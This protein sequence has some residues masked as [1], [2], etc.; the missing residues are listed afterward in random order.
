MMV[1]TL[2]L[3]SGSYFHKCFYDDEKILQDKDSVS[4]ILTS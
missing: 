2:D 1:G 3:G 4:P